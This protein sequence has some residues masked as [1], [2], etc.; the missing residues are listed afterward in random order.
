[1]EHQELRPHSLVEFVGPSGAV[2][3][4][5]RGGERG[6]VDS[7]GDG[8]A[9]VIWERSPLVVAWPQE[10]LRKVQADPPASI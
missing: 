2:L 4:W 8:V 10:W 7:L 3:Q 5:P 9:R 1:M 6:A